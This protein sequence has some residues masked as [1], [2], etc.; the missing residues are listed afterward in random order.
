[1]KLRLD[2]IHL[3]HA[4][5]TG[6]IKIRR[7]ETQTVTLPEWQYGSSH[8]PEDSPVAY[9]CARVPNVIVI[10]ASFYRDDHAAG[11]LEI[12]AV[13][14]ADDALGNV[15]KAM[16]KFKPDG[17]SDLV[18]FNLLQ[19]K[20]ANRG[21]GA[22]TT[23][24]DWQY[25]APEEDKWNSFDESGHRIYS[26]FG[27]PTD[28]WDKEPPWA[29]VLEHACR[30]AA[31][32]QN[33]PEAATKITEQI[34]ALGKGE[35]DQ[36][37]L[38][39][40]KTPVYAKKRFDCTAFLQLLRDGI[41][42]GQAVNCDD[43]ATIV[44]TFANILGCELYQSGMRND[45]HTHHINL[46]GESIWKTAGFPRHAVAWKYP[47]REANPLY[48][49]CLQ[50]DGD[51]DPADHN[52]FEPLLPANLVFGSM[53]KN[54]YKFCLFK[55]GRCDPMPGFER[56]R[57]QLGRGYVGENRIR[58]KA[59]LKLLKEHHE[60]HKWAGDKELG[61]ANTPTSITDTI[62]RQPAFAGWTCRTPQKYHSKDLASVTQLLLLPPEERPQRL[63][64]VTIYECR[65]NTS[66]SEF[67]L[68]MLAQFHQMDLKRLE[69]PIG[70]VTFVEPDN[71]AVLFKVGM[72]VALIRS[73]GKFPVSI[74]EMA[75]AIGQEYFNAQSL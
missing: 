34:F 32:A 9:L 4:A 74:F 55:S 42:S 33:E 25:R 72:F 73:V 53:D 11:E 58:G 18:P 69:Q 22:S 68:Q 30:W 62:V 60:F 56:K 36:K 16:V 51:G 2:K 3:N 57:R 47:C 5:A 43:C 38:T 71:T 6:A 24:W 17:Y 40:S 15:S 66:P 41:G 27:V 10:K 50:V 13:A 75:Q 14:L 1:M 23:T 28:P 7:N 67:V 26:V 20:I 45:I 37:T 48:D 61:H 70:D 52:E 35:V 31:G 54:L 49:A 29:E 8:Q 44:S 65:E 64:E 59:F 46:I 21:V 63:V 12:Q 19:A 39:Y